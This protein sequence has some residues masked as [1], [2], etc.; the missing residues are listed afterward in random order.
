MVKL[1]GVMKNAYF[2]ADGKYHDEI[3]MGKVLS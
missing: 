2:G 1:K 3:V